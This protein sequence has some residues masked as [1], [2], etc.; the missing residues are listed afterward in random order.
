MKTR[1]SLKCFVNDL[2]SMSDTIITENNLM[3]LGGL[4]KNM[5]PCQIKGC[6]NGPCQKNNPVFRS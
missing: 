4:R 3:W 2:G 1:V 5:K 6:L